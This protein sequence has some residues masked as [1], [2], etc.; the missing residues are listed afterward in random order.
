MEIPTDAVLKAANTLSD[1]AWGS[2]LIIVL[3]VSIAASVYLIRWIRQLHT[4]IM[5]LADRRVDDA[6]EH[7]T[8]AA[9]ATERALEVAFEA[10][11]A[12]REMVKVVE[13]VR[14][15]VMLCPTRTQGGSQ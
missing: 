11:Q 3:A 15:K 4:Q 9:A 8:E 13:Q 2:I 1:E 10:K 12:T 5:A 14:D 6:N 7:S